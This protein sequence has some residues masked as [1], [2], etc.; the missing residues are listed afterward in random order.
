MLKKYAVTLYDSSIVTL[1]CII[2]VLYTC[3]SDVYD[4]K[5]HFEHLQPAFSIHMLYGHKHFEQFDCSSFLHF[6]ISPRHFSYKKLVRNG[7]CAARTLEV[8]QI[9]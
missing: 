7:I 8:V 9:A 4:N 3:L 2:V 5:K 6:S 1:Y